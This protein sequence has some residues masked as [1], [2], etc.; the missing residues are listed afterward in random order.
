MPRERTYEESVRT[1]GVSRASLAEGPDE[2]D[3]G[4]TGEFWD[5][6]NEAAEDD[7]LEGIS[8]VLKG[9]QPGWTMFERL[10]IYNGSFYVVT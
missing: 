9:H 3:Q 2:L 8:T 7:E 6:G 10:Y 1:Y 4:Q 5:G